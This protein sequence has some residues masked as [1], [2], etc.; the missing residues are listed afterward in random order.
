[1][2]SFTA[3][4]F[5]V[6][7]TINETW[8][9]TEIR[10]LSFIGNPAKTK[11]GIAFGQSTF[12]NTDQFA[13]G[14]RMVQVFM[15]DMD[16]CILKR[17][18]DIGN[19]FESC[20]FRNSNYHYKAKAYNGNT[21]PS[22]VVQPGNH[23]GCD[24]FYKCEF[25]GAFKASVFIDGS[26]EGVNGQHIFRDCVFQQN[27]GFCF[28]VKRYSNS[29]FTP[30]LVVENTWFEFNSVTDVGGVISTS[31]PVDID[32]VFS[33][34]RQFYLNEANAKIE[35]CF[36]FDIELI[37][38]NVITKGTAS[39]LLGVLP[40]TNVIKDKYSSIT[41][42]EVTSY[43]DFMY[44]NH[45]PLYL[46]NGTADSRTTITAPRQVISKSNDNLVYSNSFAER[47]T[48]LFSG[49]TFGNFG[50]LV[51][52]GRLFDR[53]F[54]MTFDSINNNQDYIMDP[55]GEFV[56]PRD[57]FYFWSIDIKKISGDD[58]EIAYSKDFKLGTYVKI[59]NKEWTTL[60]GLGDTFGF[61]TTQGPLTV[62][63]LV[64]SKNKNET[65]RVSCFQ[66]L[67]FD[68]QQELME[69][70]DSMQFRTKTDKLISSSSILPTTGSYNIGDLIYNTNPTPGG[71]V[72]WICTTSGTP[73]TWKTFG[74]IT[75]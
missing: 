29:E 18:G 22:G 62:W 12:E 16:I 53:C 36:V 49:D 17:Y 23:S 20:S 59:Q 56:M 31:P 51:K 48:L 66:V 40:K 7:Y 57:K 58:L 47:E 72:G 60:V 4:G 32:G 71:Y 67:A 50:R 5:A 68:S 26:T 19:Y 65:F 30:G 64:F 14:I 3:T 21:T 1:L 61:P 2:S 73:G 11:N 44:Y 46:N 52:D 13:G 41:F 54:E 37:K 69:Y 28:Y 6:T 42:D 74:L 63:P 27:T 9:P 35:N 10:N 24:T 8:S 15:T 55:L 45:R 43:E 25:G 38:S 75:V 39:A 33:V 70:S 34:P